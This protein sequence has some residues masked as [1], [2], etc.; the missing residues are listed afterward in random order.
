MIGCYVLCRMMWR[1]IWLDD[2]NSPESDIKPGNETV[3]RSMLNEAY[4]RFLFLWQT[5][6]RLSDVGLGVLLSFIAMWLHI[7]ART[8]GLNR[9]KEFANCL[10]KTIRAA[11]KVL[12]SRQ[13]QF[14]KWVCCPSCSA[15][16]PADKC[17]VQLP[18][19]SKASR[20]CSHIP[21]PNHPQARFRTCCGTELMKTVRSSWG[22][23]YLYPRQMYCYNSLIEF[24]KGKLLQPGFVHRCETWRN[25]TTQ[26]GVF[27]DV[28]DGQVWKDFMNPDGTPFLSVPYNFA[29]SLNVDWFQPYKRSVYSTGIIY[30]A[31]L[32]LPRTEQFTS[33]NILLLGVIPGPK[34]PE[35]TIN[36]FLKPLVEE[37]LKLW[38]AILMQTHDNRFVLVRAA[39]LCV[40]CDVPAARKVCGFSGRRAFRG[41]SKCLKPFPTE[42]FGEKADYTGFKR[43]EWEPRTLDMHK[44]SARL[45]R[46]AT[47]LV[48]QKSIERESG[49]RYSVLLELPYFDPIRMCVVDP[50]HN[51]LGT[52]K[53]MLSVWTDLNLLS[54]THFK[55]IQIKV[56]SFSTPE[57]VGRIPTKIASGFSGFKADQWRNWTVIFSLFCLKEILPRSD[58]NCWKKFVKACHLLCCRTITLE[59]LHQADELLL[60]FCTAFAQLYGKDCCNINLH[61]HGHLLLTMAQCIPFGSFPLND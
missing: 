47:T 38:N 22:T 54:P 43:E 13:D 4:L 9:L 20:N 5:I 46:A 34:E 18:D 33:E 61:L 27:G 14:T 24:F 12:G 37:L 49:C 28:Y 35:L 2:D 26:E 30:L 29:L 53:H 6:F 50:M 52:A 56:D 25:R 55:D 23:T 40:A 15:L 3:P 31:V 10:P 58:Y 59:Q 44:E 17:V 21:F 45:H 8:L 32:N 11:R 57:D 60:E 41:C 7:L 1:Y 19:G 51:L 16:Y 48:A 39:L 36:T 42:H